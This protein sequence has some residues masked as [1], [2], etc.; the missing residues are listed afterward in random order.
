MLTTIVFQTRKLVTSGVTADGFNVVEQNVI[1]LFNLCQLKTLFRE[2]ALL[3]V[4]GT[5]RGK[6]AN[7]LP[8]FRTRHCGSL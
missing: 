5:G 7:L 3:F 2:I 6:N 4:E 1:C 8:G